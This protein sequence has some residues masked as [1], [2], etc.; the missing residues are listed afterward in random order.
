[1][2]SASAC[3]LSTVLPGAMMTTGIPTFFTCSTTGAGN[4]SVTLVGSGETVLIPP[5]KGPYSGS[6]GVSVSTTGQYLL[7]VEATGLWE[8]SLA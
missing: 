3:A 4:F 6:K 7:N 8:V 5:I 1:M 2:G